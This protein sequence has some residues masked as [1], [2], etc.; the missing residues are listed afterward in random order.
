MRKTIQFSR[1]SSSYNKH[2]E[3]ESKDIIILNDRYGLALSAFI[4][5]GFTDL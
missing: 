2:K 5:A 1:N 3:K 4:Y